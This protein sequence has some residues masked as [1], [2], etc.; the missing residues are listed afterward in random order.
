MAKAPRFF[1]FFM[2]MPV[3]E[4]VTN[5]TVGMASLPML[6]VPTLKKQ[7]VGH[8]SANIKLEQLQ[9]FSDKNVRN[10]F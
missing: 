4:Y 2:K 7:L 3:T 9:K 8:N 6:S 1:N 10:M 5:K